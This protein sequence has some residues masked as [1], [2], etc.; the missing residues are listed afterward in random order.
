MAEAP[1]YIAESVDW[2]V[3]DVPYRVTRQHVIDYIKSIYPSTYDVRR[4]RWVQK[5]KIEVRV[6]QTFLNEVLKLKTC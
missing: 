3:T 5:F 1:V 2:V 4:R 6:A